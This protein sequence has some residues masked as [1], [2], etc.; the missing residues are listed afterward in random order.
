MAVDSFPA[1][2]TPCAKPRLAIRA[3]LTESFVIVA[4]CGYLISYA[5]R[6]KIPWV[7]RFYL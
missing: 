2:S 5:F 3:G 6:L 7:K 4:T 1:R